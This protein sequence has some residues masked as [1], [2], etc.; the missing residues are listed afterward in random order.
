[1]AYSDLWKTQLAQDWRTN[2]AYIRNCNNGTWGSWYELIT[3][4]NIASQ[5]VSS[6]TSASKWAIA[7]TITLSGDVTGSVSIDGS[8]NVTLTTTVGNDSHTHGY[9]TIN[10]TETKNV[11]RLQ[12]F[13][14]SNN[15][16]LMPDTGWWSLL[17]T[18]HAGYTNGY[19]QEMA[20]SF[21]LL[22]LSIHASLYLLT[23][24]SF[25]II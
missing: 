8:A 12:M 22:F 13:Q 10:N 17:R 18:Q 4:G 21:G 14:V 11:G 24:N 1:M 25:F 7:R 20:Y 9:L 6:A 15:S 19:W 16:T 2:T 23:V 3:S 5:S